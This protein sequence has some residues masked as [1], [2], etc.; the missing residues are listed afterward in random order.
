MHTQTYTQEYP[1]SH[2][3]TY[4]QHNQ[5]H[6]HTKGTGVLSLRQMQWNMPIIPA[7]KVEVGELQV[8]DQLE[9]YS[10]TS[11]Q[12]KAGLC[13][14]SVGNVIATQSPVQISSQKP[15]VVEKACSP[16]AGR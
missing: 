9:Q 12:K 5:G 11:S 4:T 7:K 6:I 10:V 13:D 3:R 15:A 8:Q 1:C 16:S 2:T 14:G